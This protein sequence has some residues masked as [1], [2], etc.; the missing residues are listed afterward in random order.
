L[1]AEYG[2]REW[3]LDHDPIAVLIQTILSQNTSDQNSNR[4]FTS[5]ASQF[6]GW[7]KVAT[8]S[9]SKIEESIRFGGLAKVKAVYIKQ[10]LMEIRQ[11][12]GKLSLEF[13]KELTVDKARN[14]LI[15]LP[16]VGMKTASCVLLFSLGMPALPVDTHVSRLSRRLGLISSKEPIDKAHKVLENIV[17]RNDVYAFHVLLIEHGRKICKAQCPRCSRC[18]LQ[19]ICPSYEELSKCEFT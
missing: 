13:L 8:A 19:N 18:V 9:T 7:D 4:A 12:R 11:R 5:L 10:A 15:R 17:T 1:T 14:W 3:R 16:G 2:N 6:T